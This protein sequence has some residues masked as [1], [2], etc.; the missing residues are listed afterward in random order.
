MCSGSPHVPDPAAEDREP[1]Y[2]WRRRIS[3]LNSSVTGSSLRSVSLSRTPP[4]LL[5]CQGHRRA[6]AQPTFENT[7]VF[8]ENFTQP[9]LIVSCIPHPGPRQVP[10]LLPTPQLRFLYFVSTSRSHP[11]CLES[12]NLCRPSVLYC[13]SEILLS[14]I[15][16]ESYFLE[17]K[18]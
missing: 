8:L 5:L 14:F 17:M 10:S 12:L 13:F 1:A 4:T 11:W 18:S 2:L 15:F 16:Y 6:G 9:S 3:L 7:Y